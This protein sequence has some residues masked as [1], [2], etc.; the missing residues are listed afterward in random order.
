MSRPGQFGRWIWLWLACYFVLM[1]V[2]VW[3]MLAA[4]QWALAELASPQA[5]NDWQ[6][7]REDVK[8]QQ[9]ESGPVR[10]RVPKSPEPPAA[11]L[12]RDNFA[13]LFAGAVVL[14]SFLFWVVAWF[15]T[16]AWT[17]DGADSDKETG[18]QGDKETKGR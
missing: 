4:R 7:W 15:L 13:V 9:T 3:S 16:G 18:R 6:A 11:V 8:R 17:A 14:S 5:N 10:L 12:L 1:G 2:I